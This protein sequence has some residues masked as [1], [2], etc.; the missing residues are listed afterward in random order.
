MNQNTNSPQYIG[1]G[2]GE[3]HH[4]QEL[5]IYGLPKYLQQ[6]INELKLVVN[7]NDGTG[8]GASAEPHTVDV[9][10]AARKE[11]LE[12]LKKAL[13]ADYM[14]GDMDA[15]TGGSLTNVAIKATM[16]NL[17]MKASRYEWQAFKFVQDVLK[18]FMFFQKQIETLW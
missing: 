5:P 10:Y 3:V 15:M 9:P 13:Y 11:A 18:L 16:A 7:Q 6:Y 17:D 2:G 4:K 1:I 12:L 14:A 8:G